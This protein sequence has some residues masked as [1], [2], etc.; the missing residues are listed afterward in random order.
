MAKVSAVP[1]NSHGAETARVTKICS[2]AA[3]V[4]DAVS[5]CASVLPSRNASGGHITSKRRPPGLVCQATCAHDPMK[6]ASASVFQ[7]VQVAISRLRK[8]MPNSMNS[9]PRP[10]SVSRTAGCRRA[11][12][13][14]RV[15]TR[16]RVAVGVCVI[17]QH[18]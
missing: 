14:G 11:G 16:F 15:A 10:V 3:N 17:E 7:P 6:T 1:V 13:G 18:A 4:P 9:A 5:S 12:G 2:R 8:L